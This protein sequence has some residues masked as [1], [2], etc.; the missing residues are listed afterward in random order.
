MTHQIF[1]QVE[2]V[3]LYISIRQG[4]LPVTYNLYFQFGTGYCY[5]N[6]TA[7]FCKLFLHSPLLLP[8]VKE[9]FTAIHRLDCEAV[10]LIKIK[11]RILRAFSNTCAAVNKNKFKLQTLALVNCHDVYCV[12]FFY[13]V[14][15]FININFYLVAK[16]RNF[17]IFNLTQLIC[18][19]GNA[20]VILVCLAGKFKKHVKLFGIKTFAVA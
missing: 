11:L 7:E 15:K 5:I 18:K 12:T 13:R 9:I 1:N 17:F 6:Q 8:E 19:P 20:F 2:R 16:G 4:F 3:I 14:G 10:F